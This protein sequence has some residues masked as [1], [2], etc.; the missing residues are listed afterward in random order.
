MLM[1]KSKS[2][3]LRPT[4]DAVEEERIVHGNVLL[5]DNLDHL[6]SDYAARQSADVMHFTA[7]STYAIIWSIGRKADSFESPL[8]D[9]ERVMPL[10]P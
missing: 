6:L 9:L 5:R 8:T 2:Q 3:R 7:L 4:R 1:L 10:K